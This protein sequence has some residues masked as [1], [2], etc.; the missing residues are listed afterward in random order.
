[1]PKNVVLISNAQSAGFKEFVFFT[2]ISAVVVLKECFAW[3]AS[4]MFFL[5]FLTYSIE[6]VDLVKS[7][8]TVKISKKKKKKNYSYRLRIWTQRDFC[9]WVSHYWVPV[10]CHV[11]QMTKSVHSGEC[12]HVCKNVS[13]HVFIYLFHFMP[14]LSF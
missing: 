11:Q 9:S 1:M 14:M 6:C 5:F 3:W 10:V 13:F 7:E 8:S 2:E 4:W 12:Q